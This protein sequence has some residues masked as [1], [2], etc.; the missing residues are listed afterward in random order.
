MF[1]NN[2]F[3]T[4]SNKDHDSEHTYWS[5]R[6]FMQALGIMGS[7]AIMLN[8][9]M[10]AASSNT[11]L[12][13][14]INNSENENILILI[15]LAGGND[16][17]N[18]IIP[19]NQYDEYANARP[20]IRIQENKLIKLND[21]FGIPD[22]LNDFKELW[23]EGQFK[24]VNG[25]GHGSKQSLSHFTR[26]EIWSNADV[27]TTKFTGEETGW[28]GRHLEDLYPNYLLSPPPS[29]AAIQIGSHGDILFQGN[30]VNYGFTATNTS[31][32]E[33]IA[34]FG[35]QYQIQDQL[36][37][38]C[39]YDNQL[40]FLRGV[41]NTTY[42]YSGVINEAF[43]KGE[44]QVEYDSDELSRQLSLIARLIKGNLGTK[45]Y[46]IT[47]GGFDTHAQQTIDH[48]KLLVRLSKS[49]NN[50]FKDLAF[51]DQDKSTLAMTYSEFGRRIKENGSMGTDHGKAGPMMVFGKGLNGNGIVGKHPSLK[52]SETDNG[53][54]KF[55]IDFRDVYATILAE[56]MCVPIPTIEQFLLGHK[57][58]PIDLGI[59][60][61]NENKPQQPEEPLSIETI[62]G[63]IKNKISHKV[64][65][66]E[67][68]NPNILIEIPSYGR[69]KIDLFNISGQ[70]QASIFD[71]FVFKNKFSV[72]ITE[73]T[74]QTLSP[75]I[76]IYLIEIDGQKFSDKFIV[77]D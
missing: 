74:D 4:R 5:R 30:N 66:L 62:D 18:T 44:N 2:N 20:N 40:K 48:R 61:S 54:L 19:I 64:I 45:V 65:Y 31:E 43:N 70:K 7:G 9:K 75:G 53:N 59:S 41:A 8:S 69:V 50:F 57:F 11:P 42:E 16:G 51:T 68:S 17:L 13:M 22:Y 71:E 37:K 21:N 58:K 1:T 77:K 55:N 52:E 33:H 6:S 32:L 49:V 34:R 67:N 35:T 26:S 73:K 76:Y 23:D 63:N 15:R 3:N 39:T 38:D 24:V 36:F 25:V 47:L 27:E 60:C 46:M 14:S 29:P 56:W 12:S 10:V 72:D 28:M